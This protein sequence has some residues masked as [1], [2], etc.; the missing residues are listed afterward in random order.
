MAYQKQNFK[1][2]D[3]LSASQLNH[4]EDGILDLENNTPFGGVADVRI[5]GES[6]VSNNIA[7]AK[8][9]YLNG[10]FLLSGTLQDFSVVMQSGICFINLQFILP[11][12][13]FGDYGFYVGEISGIEALIRTWCNFDNMFYCEYTG[14]KTAIRVNGENLN[15]GSYRI[16]TVF[17][18]R[19]IS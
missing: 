3:V 19:K 12:E 10:N 16:N 9:T 5:N 8:I 11:S 4:I 14:A 15:A 7:D 13:V 17:P 6:I 1:D 18:C 2:G